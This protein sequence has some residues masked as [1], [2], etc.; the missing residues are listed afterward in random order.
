MLGFSVH[1][2]QLS[3]RLTVRLSLSRNTVVQFKESRGDPLCE[4]EL[5]EAFD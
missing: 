1:C 4:E 3:F 5:D 2:S